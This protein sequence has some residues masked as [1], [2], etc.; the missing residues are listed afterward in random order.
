MR[1]RGATPSSTPCAPRATSPSERPTRRRTRPGWRW[2]LGASRASCASRTSASACAQEAERILGSLPGVTDGALAVRTGGYRI[3]TT[4]D[5]E[6]QQEAKRLVAQW[7]A[8]LSGFN[9]NNSALVAIDSAT[10]EIVSY[11]GSVDY[12]NR[13]SPE[14]QGQF[15]VAG[16][17]RRQPGSAFK[18]ITY[19]S[20]FKSRDATV[21]TML[22]DAMTEF[23][24]DGAASYRPTNADIKEHGPVLALDALRYSL[25]IPSVQMQFLVGAPDDGRLRRVARHRQRASTSWARIR[26]SPWR[27]D[28]CRS[29]SRT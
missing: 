25:N 8:T 17:G 7:V 10:G 13:E 26:A 19:S 3:T 14:V 23:G 1:W 2:S 27:S 18:P 16:L 5:Y 6:L 12:Y 21:S 15:D 22:V 24:V 29:T 4:L 9:V 28:R 20:A 11:V